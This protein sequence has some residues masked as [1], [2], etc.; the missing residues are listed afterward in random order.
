MRRCYSVQTGKRGSRATPIIRA[1][2]SMPS[3]LPGL[4][5][6][7]PYA[8]RHSSITRA[9]QRGLSP[10]LVA[11]AHDTSIGM[12]ERNYSKF[13]ADHSDYRR[14][15]AQID[16]AP[17]AADPV[18]AV[19]ATAGASRASCSTIRAAAEQRG[20]CAALIRRNPR[21]G[22][23]DRDV[24]RS[25]GRAS[26]RRPGR[27]RLRNCCASIAAR[28]SSCSPITPTCSRASSRC[29]RRGR[30]TARPY[31]GGAAAPLSRAARSRTPFPRPDGCARPPA[32]VT[33][34]NA[35]TIERPSEPALPSPRLRRPGCERTDPPCRT[36]RTR[37]AG[38]PPGSR[39]R[40][41]PPS[42]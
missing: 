38:A 37:G 16:L 27:R 39:R 31:D 3:R 18:G 25:Q 9:L 12:L 2:S 34:D 14:R 21:P 23:P 20:F 24:R 1:R 13:I 19:G 40:C 33:L 41:R 7:V 36:D 35:F 42:A 11:D 4:P 26:P 28:C 6:V 22:R 32:A 29:C 17:A 15:A 10:R 5:K 30:K 8:L